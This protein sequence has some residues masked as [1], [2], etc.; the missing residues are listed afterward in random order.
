[1]CGMEYL[2]HPTLYLACAYLYMLL[3]NSIHDSKIGPWRDI[4][5]FGLIEMT[6]LLLIHAPISVEPC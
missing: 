3:L 4:E 5:M 2:L 1:M 6:L